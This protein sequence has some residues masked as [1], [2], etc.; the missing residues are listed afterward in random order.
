MPA[1]IN[2]KAR[3]K[4]GNKKTVVDGIK[5][6]SIAEAARYGALK[7]MVRA[8]M[9]DSLELQKRYK[10]EVNGVLVCSYVADFVYRFCGTGV[11]V[12]EDV[13]GMKT[14]VYNLKKKLMKAIH[15]I[16]IREHK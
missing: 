12:C 15:G 3:Q 7:L 4:Y 6:D 10:L 2:L 9:I 13:K 8:N 1:K 14:P 5:F 16:E 11:I